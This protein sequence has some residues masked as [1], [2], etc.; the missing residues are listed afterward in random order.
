MLNA[1]RKYRQ[2]CYRNLAEALRHAW[3]EAKIQDWFTMT[4]E[5]G[6]INYEKWCQ[7]HNVREEHDHYV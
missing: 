6:E 5:K 3:L 2:G 1:H 4:K 7:E